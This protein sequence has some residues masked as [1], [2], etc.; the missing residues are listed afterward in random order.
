MAKKVLVVDKNLA[1]QKLLEFSLGEEG[2]EMSV[3][4]DGLSAL[5]TAFKNTPDLCIVEYGMEGL[6][7]PQFLDKMHQREN[8]QQVPVI[9]M[10]NA[11]ESDADPA[12]LSQKM[13]YT[14]KKPLDPIEVLEQVK[15]CLG[16][17]TPPRVLEDENTVVAWDLDLQEAEDPNLNAPNEQSKE[18]SQGESLSI[19]E[20]LGWPSSQESE[21]QETN[22]QQAETIKELRG[23]APTAPL[24]PA[25]ST[26][27]SSA[28]PLEPVLKL[29]SQTSSQVPSP[30]NSPDPVLHPA[31]GPE[32][33]GSMDS[34]VDDA[35]RRVIEEI[36]WEVVP[37]L[38]ETLLKDRV[39]ETAT[40]MVQEMVHR[41]GQEIV[42]K[43]AWEV[44]P[45]LAEHAVKKEVE[46]SIQQQMDQGNKQQ[47]NKELIEQIV[48]EVLS[49]LAQAARDQRSSSS[50]L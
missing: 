44:I 22:A 4:S 40:K 46:K 2:F 35:S 14:I 30:E 7:L 5:D 17:Q 28:E 13:V 27:I 16:V 38:T 39:Q 37:S 10:V 36:A 29:S 25:P 24:S 31:V 32:K 45:P 23:S 50:D 47:D 12:I 18:Q 42:E 21:K 15:I 19:E 49:S 8:L 1:V 41:I 43:V 3:F 48:R 26:P 34:A 11:S 6:H 20:L 9:L 33:E